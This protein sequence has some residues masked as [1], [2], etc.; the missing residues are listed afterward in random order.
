VTLLKEIKEKSGTL[1]YM[2]VKMIST[3]EDTEIREWNK[4]LKYSNEATHRDLAL[5]LYLVYTKS[6]AGYIVILFFYHIGIY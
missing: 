6:K 3:N 5:V 1:E 2:Y 4:Y